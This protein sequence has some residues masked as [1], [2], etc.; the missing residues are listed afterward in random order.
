MADQVTG[1]PP[2]QESAVNQQ[3]VEQ[4]PT[5]YSSLAAQRAQGGSQPQGAPG[6]EGDNREQFIPRA[7]FDEVVAQRQTLEQQFLQT[8]A[9][10]NQLYGAQQYAQQYAPQPEQQ[11]PQGPQYQPKVDMQNKEVLDQWQ[12]RIIN[13]GGSALAEFVAAVFEDKYN[14][15][16]VVGQVQNLLNQQVVPHFQR[17]QNQ[18]ADDYISR[19]AQQDPAFAQLGPQFKQTLATVLQERPDLDLS[20]Q[21]LGLIAGFVQQAQQVYGYQQPAPYQAPVGYP[22]GYLPQPQPYNPYVPQPQPQQYNPYTQAGQPQG[23]PSQPQVPYSERPGGPVQGQ[24]QQGQYAPLSEA[25]QRVARSY[26]MSDQEYRA[27]GALV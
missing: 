17:I 6:S 26:G 8:Q 1:L 25:E 23:Y 19:R 21:S 18:A 11:Q 5:E 24:Q 12:K 3:S 27:F 14:E 10:L 9:A 20:D 22:Q 4:L 2:A 16:N 13:E 7:R 15:V